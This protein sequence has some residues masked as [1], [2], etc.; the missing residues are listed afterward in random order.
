MDDWVTKILNEWNVP[1][2][3]RPFVEVMSTRTTSSTWVVNISRNVLAFTMR[4]PCGYFVIWETAKV[5]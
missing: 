1:K 2:I 5:K 4:A 3:Y